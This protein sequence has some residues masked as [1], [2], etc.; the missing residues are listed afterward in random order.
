[1]LWHQKNIADTLSSLN[2]SLRGLSS[3]EAQKRLERYGANEL[4]EKARKTA[5]SMFFDQFKDF[6]ILVLI[7]AA[8]ISG[9]IGEPSDTIAIIIIVVLNAVIGSVQEYRA[10]KAVA[11]LKKMS[12]ASAVVL[13]NSHPTPLP[14]SDLV[15]G[16]IVILEAGRIVP[17]DLRIIETAQ[18]KIQE[19]ALT[20][21][22]EA[23]EKHTHHLKDADIPLGDRKNTAYK[24][25]S[26]VYGRGAGIVTATGM[27]TE[28]GKIA[29]MLQD[30]EETKTPLQKRL[31]I[32]GQK[33]SVAVI[34]ICGLL[35]AVGTLRGEQPLVMFM[36]ALTLIVAAIPEALPAVVTISLALGAKKMVKQN[37]LI[38]KLPAIETLGSVT[39]ICSDK[40]GTLTMNKMAVEETWIAGRQSAVDSKQSTEKTDASGLSPIACF[41]TAF[42]LN[43]DVQINPSGETLGDPTEIA[44]Y[45][46]AKNSGFDRRALEKEM[47]RTAEI[48]F[49]S[50]RKCMTTFHKL[51]VT[52][53]RWE[54]KNERP[55]ATGN[56]IFP[57]S[58]F[59]L[60]TS[61]LSF[62]KGAFENLIEKAD[63]LL[64]ENGT[65]PID[66]KALTEESDRMAAD[67]LRV[68]CVAM[69]HWDE[70]PAKLSPEDCEKN[71]TIIGLAGI[72][73]PPRE[74]AKEAVR[75]CKSAGIK[76]VMIT[77]DH[78]LTAAAIAKRLGIL[79]E[80]DGADSVI[81]G[82]ELE[83][84]PLSEFE[85]R[86]EKIKVY[87]RV[88]PEQKLKII[89][90][91]QD[92]EQFTAMTGDGVNDAP[93]LKR[94]DIGIAMGITGTDVSKQASHM[95][96]LDDNF[97]TIVK[98]VKEGR[99]IFDGITKMIRYILSTN[100]GEI[101]LLFFAP[102]FHLPIPLLP[103]HMLWLNLVTDGL[104]SLAFAVGPAEHD[105]MS[106]PPKDPREGILTAGMVRGILWIGFLLAG[107]GIVLQAGALNIG[108]NTKWQ[109]MLFTFMCLAELGAALALTSEKQS[110]FSIPP[111]KIKTMLVAVIFTFVL[112]IC[113]VYVP[114]L[115]PIFKTVPLTFNELLFTLVASSVV[116]FAV[117][118]EKLWRRRYAGHSA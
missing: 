68:I 58:L 11:A 67:G 25:T 74:E 17:A 44:L 59:P 72:M 92:R 89:K 63:Y 114:A 34:A 22:S 6:M 9:I 52:S 4:K 27:Q 105:I 109:T 103:I 69:R 21:E 79:E 18:L 49:D 71:L 65:E 86:V 60:N 20:G 37:A 61:Y 93:A 75:L 118:I 80:S 108:M 77:G 32:F 76:P 23:V 8:I 95:V 45:E 70:M 36:T 14:A 41:Y 53:A 26:V 111:K 15:P 29:G 112:Q 7:A 91:L 94:S 101:M 107:V 85:T 10:E 42:A 96:L 24:G 46:L 47:P 43:N 113:V 115:N 19:A 110:F 97:A 31:T 50:D 5:L 84:L 116:F 100:S 28:L 12:A 3:D 55:E 81:T 1:M 51:E 117:E 66:K 83:Q 48:P 2:S 33:L 98:A 87:A 99:R 73:D 38:R 16:D 102:L 82:R 62:T 13:R 88:A 78:P 40:T 39:F 106:R 56:K 57:P 35:F 90:A 54:V 30:E 64:S 104:P